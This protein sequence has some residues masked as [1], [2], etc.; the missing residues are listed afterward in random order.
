MGVKRQPSDVE[1][2][3]QALRRVE[4]DAST[5]LAHD[6]RRNVG[7]L[8]RNQRYFGTIRPAQDSANS[9]LRRLFLRVKLESYQACLQMS[10]ADI[11]SEVAR[12]QRKLEDLKS[13]APRSEMEPPATP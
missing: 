4:Y 3:L 6:Q 7:V 13:T 9:A 2:I 10:K 12:M 1:E 5:R 11:E 8:E